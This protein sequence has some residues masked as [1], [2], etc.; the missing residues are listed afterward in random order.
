M[1]PSTLKHSAVTTFTIPQEKVGQ[2]IDNFLHTH[3]KG[4]P[5]SHIYRILR[6]GQVRINKGR[7]KPTY[8]LAMGDLLRLPPIQYQSTH[9]YTPSANRL[10]E[11]EHAILYEDAL[12]LIINKPSGLAVHGGTGIHGGLI[13]ALRVL[14][15]NAPHLELVHRLDRDTSGCL[16]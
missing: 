9:P 3:L 12:L 7:I 5:R 6:T 2:R 10:K 11:L 15:P 13:E 4:V 14:Y 16:M 1:N 8:R